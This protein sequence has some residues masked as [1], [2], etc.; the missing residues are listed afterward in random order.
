MLPYGN[1]TNSRRIMSAR[2]T[3]STDPKAPDPGV[4]AL[5]TGTTPGYFEAIGV[6]LLRGRDFTQA[7]SENKDG[8]RIAI[9]DEE[10]AKKLFPN[11]D[12]LGQHVRYTIPPKDGTPNDM[13]VVGV[14]GTHRHDVQNDTLLTRLFVPFAQGYSGDVVLHVRFNT[15]DRQAVAG[16]IP[17]MRSTLR[18]I[19]PY[20]PILTIAP[21]VDLME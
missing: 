4:S 7:E 1:F 5:Y 11:E 9:I 20:M 16:M 3:L 19:D 15:L 17:T 13:E 10:M 14:V 2:A 8:R 21:W 12:A 6:K 18:E